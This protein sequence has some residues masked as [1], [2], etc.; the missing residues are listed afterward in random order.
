[1]LLEVLRPLEGL[2]AKIASV[3]LQGYVDADV[4]GDMVALHDGH[5]AATPTTSEIEVVGALTPNMS[6]TNMILS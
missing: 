6:F 4:R 3:G 5:A 2:S 1:M